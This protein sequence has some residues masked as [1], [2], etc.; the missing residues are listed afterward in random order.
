[1]EGTQEA[2]VRLQELARA[3]M[4]VPGGASQVSIDQSGSRGRREERARRAPGSGLP[5]IGI[6][7]KMREKPIEWVGSSR[8]D[9]R[10]F[11]A[12]VRAEAGHDLFLLQQGEPPRNWKPMQGVGPGVA[13]IRLRTWAGGRLEHRVL[14][15]AKFPEAVY[16][17]HAFRKTT[18]ATAQSELE[19]ARQRY[20]QLL[21]RR[22]EED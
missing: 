8:Q 14:Y 20:R 7:Y 2:G 4:E 9:L 21:E 15:V 3:D 10:A 13:E 1:M 18:R 12:E 17:L 5:C 22:R 11:P 19:T 6:L 16:V